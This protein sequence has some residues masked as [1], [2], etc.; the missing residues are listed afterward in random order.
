MRRDEQQLH[1]RVAVDDDR[2][3]HVDDE[4]ENEALEDPEVDA[5]G[6]ESGRVQQG[7]ELELAEDGKEQAVESRPFLHNPNR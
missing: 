4:A 5:P 6:D 7:P 3:E 1:L 2:D